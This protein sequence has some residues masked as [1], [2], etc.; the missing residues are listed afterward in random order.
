MW[1][2]VHSSGDR[3]GVWGLVFKLTFVEIILFVNN[4]QYIHNTQESSGAPKA[5]EG[6][7]WYRAPKE[8]IKNTDFVDMTMSRL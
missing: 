4:E 8:K 1:Y 2:I 7:P 3:L 6:V 5:G